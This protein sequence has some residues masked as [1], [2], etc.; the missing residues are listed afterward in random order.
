MGT[1]APAVSAPTLLRGAWF[2][3]EQCGLL[4]QDAVQLWEAGRESSALALAMFARE[5]LERHSILI[6]FWRVAEAGKLVSVEQVRKGCDDHVTKQA[7][8]QR[9]Y[10]FQ[11]PLGSTL[12]TLFTAAKTLPVGTPEHAA[13]DA[14][15][16]DIMRRK[17]KSEPKRR[18][19][20]RMAAVY[21][22]IDDTGRRW[23]C[24]KDVDRKTALD[25]LF[26]AVNDYSGAREAITQPSNPLC[27][28]L[29]SALAAWPERPD[30]ARQVWPTKL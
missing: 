27:K 20:A 13:L 29:A 18:H 25:D 12:D 1:K 5:E 16:N 22:D 26:H 17:S 28:E 10:I 21:V 14:Y 7:E 30:L 23:A 9:S 8:A 24:P 6:G 19:R 2:A 4:L 3:L 15:V 11:E